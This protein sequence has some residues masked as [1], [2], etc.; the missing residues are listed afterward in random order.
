[1]T[2]LKHNDQSGRS[3]VEMLGVLAIIGVLSVGGI[4]GYSKAMAKFKLVKAQDQITM[5]LMNIRAAY[6]T[7]PTYSGLT[8]T[9]AAEYNLAPGDMIVSTSSATKLYGAFGGEVT[10]T[11][12]GDSDNYF[13]ITMNDLGKEA[14]RSLGSSDWGT[15]G[16]IKMTINVSGDVSAT[17]TTGQTASGNWCV[18]ELPAKLID[19]NSGC[20]QPQNFITWVYY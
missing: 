11:T 5:L 15:D 3:M 10:V 19:V 16:L 6:A 8:S 14:C 1:M 13:S 17:C 9:V 20:D 2:I 4:S 18:S 7:S 12:L